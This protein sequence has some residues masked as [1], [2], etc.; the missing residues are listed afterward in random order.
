MATQ[1]AATQS[2]RIAPWGNSEAIRIPQALLRAAGL[3]AGD[4]VNIIINERNNI[5]VVQKPQ[6]HRCVK[7]TDG[8]T[9][10]TLFAGFDPASLASAAPAWPT[11]DMEGAEFEAWSS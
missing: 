7:P 1:A 6:E 8:I 10:D 4:D 3:S 9:F 5:E 11:D 2:T